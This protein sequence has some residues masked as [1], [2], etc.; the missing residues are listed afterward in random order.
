MADSPGTGGTGPDRNDR[1]ESLTRRLDSLVGRARLTLWWEEAWPLIWVP[2][3]ILL[4]FLTASWLGLWLDATPLMLGQD[5]IA[6]LFVAGAGHDL[7][8]KFDH[9]DLD[10]EFGRRCGDLRR[11]P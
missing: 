2:I 7:R 4:V 5:R 1:Q 9:C 3:T 11:R 10:V 6:D 8:R